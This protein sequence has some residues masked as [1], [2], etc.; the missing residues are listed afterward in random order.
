[1]SGTLGRSVENFFPD[2]GLRKISEWPGSAGAASL[3][4]KAALSAELRLRRQPADGIPTVICNWELLHWSVDLLQT[5][6]L[7][8][9]LSVSEALLCLGCSSIAGARTSVRAKVLSRKMVSGERRLVPRGARPAFSSYDGWAADLAPRGVYRVLMRPP[10]SY[11]SRKKLC[12]PSEKP[13]IA[14][15]NGRLPPGESRCE[16]VVACRT[17]ARR[18]VSRD[19]KI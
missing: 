4:S 7:L 11:C 5:P 12:S 19:T 15:V 14:S 16:N 18:S 10:S 3:H 1:M 2:Q 8:A 9:V 6:W 13:N 17:S